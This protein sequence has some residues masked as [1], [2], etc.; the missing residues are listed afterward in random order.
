MQIVDRG[1]GVP[2]VLVPGIQGRW[3]Y[4]GRTVDALAQAFRVITFRRCHSQIPMGAPH[5]SRRAGR[6][7]GEGR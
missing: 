4:L 7:H 5:E 6:Q 3:E 2:I 1:H